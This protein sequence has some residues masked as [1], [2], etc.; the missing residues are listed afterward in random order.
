M[1]FWLF[2]LS[3]GVN[4][5]WQVWGINILLIKERLHVQAKRHPVCIVMQNRSIM[6]EL[7]N[8]FAESTNHLFTL[9]A[10]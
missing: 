8:Q 1:M 10:N 4:A 6:A 5:G 9:M 7:I 2:L 3:T